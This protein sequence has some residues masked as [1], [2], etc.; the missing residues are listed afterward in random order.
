MTCWTV[1]CQKWVL[2]FAGVQN[3]YSDVPKK[4]AFF[5]CLYLAQEDS[6]PLWL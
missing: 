6:L 2:G 5:K 3:L 4:G 1:G